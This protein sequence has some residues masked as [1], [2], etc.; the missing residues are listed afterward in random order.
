MGDEYLLI[1]RSICLNC[2]GNYRY[3]SKAFGEHGFYYHV[4]CHF[5]EKGVVEQLVSV[6]EVF[7]E[8]FATKIAR[9]NT[10][11]TLTELF[12]IKRKFDE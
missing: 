7:E 6:E 12:K 5:C 4:D 11:G 8:Y 10:R 3:K 9:H 1:K 2:K